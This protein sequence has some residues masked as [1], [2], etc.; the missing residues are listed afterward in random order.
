MNICGK[1]S[2]VSATTCKDGVVLIGF[3]GNV[4]WRKLTDENL[5]HIKA[6][7]GMSG[8]KH[9]FCTKWIDGIEPKYPAARSNFHSF[10]LL[11]K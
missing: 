7:C 11:E 10:L 6:F 1:F 2:R 5:E 8:S 3:C 9:T 4:T